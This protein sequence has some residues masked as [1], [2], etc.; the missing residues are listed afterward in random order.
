MFSRATISWSPKAQLAQGG[1]S[2][3]FNRVIL[4]S[5]DSQALPPSFFKVQN[6]QIRGPNP[7]RDHMKSKMRPASDS[8]CSQGTKDALES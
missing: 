8:D 5:L 2:S 4:R 3:P 1:G 7:I 6:H